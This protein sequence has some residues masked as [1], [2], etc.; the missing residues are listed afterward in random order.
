MIGRLFLV[1][2]ICALIASYVLQQRETTQPFPECDEASASEYYAQLLHYAD[3]SSVAGYKELKGECAFSKNYESA[4]SKFLGAA[5]AVPGVVMTKY[6]IGDPKDGLTIDVAEV[7]GSKE[8][9][10]VSVSGVHGPEG[11]AGSAI[12]SSLLKLLVDS[13]RMRELYNLGSSKKVEG[14]ETASSTAPT[15][16]FVHALNPYGFAKNRRFNEDNIDVN[17]NFLTEE[18]LDE[19]RRR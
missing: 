1:L 2:G 13:P 9:F 3:S 18:K 15:L 4:R 12:Q 10:L 14:N 6:P 7:P 19:V 5:E 16:I 17:R 8:H 11:F